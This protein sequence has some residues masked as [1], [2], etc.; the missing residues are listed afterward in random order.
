MTRR[1]TN[2]LAE[3][4]VQPGVSATRELRASLRDL[5][6]PSPYAARLDDVVLAATEL[7]TNAVLHGRQPISVRVTQLPDRLRIAVHD[8]HG[9]SPSFSLLDPTAFTGRG[10]MVVS[11][12]ADRWG[13]EPDGTGKSVWI[14]VFPV[15]PDKGDEA[16]VAALLA[17]WGDELGVDPALE[18]VR[19]VLTDM[20]VAAMTTAETY[21][22]A[23]LRELALVV[24][25]PSSDPVLVEQGQRVLEASEPF[26][27]LRADLKRQLAAATAAGRPTCDL[28][29]SITRRDA[30]SV[31]DYA[32]AIDGADR[33]ARSGRLLLQEPEAA[34][35]AT[36]R[37]YLRRIL[38]QLS[39]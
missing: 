30:E 8:T 3:L 11:A 22:E 1:E 32:A 27:G 12:V 37:E 6:D 26:D 17:S 24:H 10:L 36:R 29:L 23:A 4:Q 39:S 16:D 19:V 38:A 7:V 31:R 5:L 35:V 13:V 9:V 25:T 34:V 18:S 33:L 15:A 14:E 28:E 21:V 2:E 20:D